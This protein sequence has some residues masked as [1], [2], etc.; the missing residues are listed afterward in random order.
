MSIILAL[1][2]R[3]NL[4]PWVSKLAPY[5]IMGIMMAGSAYYI[6]SLRSKISDR[7]T[8]IST[9]NGSITSLNAINNN[10]RNEISIV[11]SKAED[12]AKSV[13]SLNEEIVLLRKT[14]QENEDAIKSYQASTAKRCTLSNEFLRLYKQV[15]TTPD[16]PSK[17]TSSGSTGAQ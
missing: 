16:L 11:T 17:N 8:T 1:L 4:P 14:S 3:F 7:D 10:L 13:S 6:H 9:L 2:G 15:T 12:T 5:I